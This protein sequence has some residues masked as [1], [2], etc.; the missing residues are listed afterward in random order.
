MW[1]LLMTGNPRLVPYREKN[2]DE[3]EK[4]FELGVKKHIS[5]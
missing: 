3:S 5:A 4:D 2:I 1:H